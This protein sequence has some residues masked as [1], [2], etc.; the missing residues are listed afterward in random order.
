MSFVVLRAFLKT[1]YDRKKILL[2]I[3]NNPHKNLFYFYVFCHRISEK[4]TP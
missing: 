1:G 3:I 2:K 4:N